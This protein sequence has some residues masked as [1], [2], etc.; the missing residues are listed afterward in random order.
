[1]SF[2][3]RLHSNSIPSRTLEFPLNQ[4]VPLNPQG[5]IE[6]NVRKSFAMMNVLTS[7]DVNP[8][9]FDRLLFI[10]FYAQ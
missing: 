3:D 5:V 1:M 6:H 7:V 10:R 9:D 4:M 2:T 8:D